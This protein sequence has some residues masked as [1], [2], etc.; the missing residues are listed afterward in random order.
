MRTRFGNFGVQSGIGNIRGSDKNRDGMAAMLTV[1]D[2]HAT[3]ERTHSV[4]L[5]FSTEKLTVREL[6]R[7]RIYQ[8]VQ[9][10]NLK[11]S[12]YFNGLVEPSEAEKTLNG[13]KL[14][15][16]RKI[17]WEEQFARALDAFGRN[18]F[19]ILVGDRQAEDLDEVLE[20]NG[21]TEVSFVKLVPLVGG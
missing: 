2:E 15:K 20:V 9:D 21:E 19:F 4:T 12:E 17:D 5:S 16:R 18:G 3:G 14:R 13:F 10:Y 6:I 8:E 11:E 7:E 1:H